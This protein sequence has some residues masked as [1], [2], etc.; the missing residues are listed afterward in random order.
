MTGCCSLPPGVLWLSVVSEVL[1]IMLLVVGFSLMCLELFHSS[2]VID[3]LKLNAFA[4]VFTVLSGMKL[5][6]PFLP[7]KSKI[8]Q[9]WENKKPEASRLSY[10]HLAIAIFHCNFLFLWHKD[11]MINSPLAREKWISSFLISQQQC[12]NYPS[13]ARTA[14]TTVPASAPFA[15]SSHSFSRGKLKTWNVEKSFFSGNP[16][17]RWRLENQRKEL[18]L[19]INKMENEKGSNPGTEEQLQEWAGTCT[20]LRTLLGSVCTWGPSPYEHEEFTSLK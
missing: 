4:A 8:P 15:A 5:S 14:I 3:G 17:S 10:P 1:Y 6:F 20:S 12:S 18:I 11:C 9:L 2:S 16:E 13:P 7:P 19:L